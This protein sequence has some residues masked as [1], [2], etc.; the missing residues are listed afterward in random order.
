MLG[1][2]KQQKEGEPESRAEGRYS[3]GRGQDCATRDSQVCDVCI[4][5]GC[6]YDLRHDKRVT[7]LRLVCLS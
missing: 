6:M 1:R 2:A 7:S 5:Y 3:I 4:E